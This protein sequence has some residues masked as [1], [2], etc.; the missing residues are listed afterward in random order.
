MP[1][2]KVTKV[3]HTLAKGL[4]IKINPPIAYQDEVTRGESV[5]SADDSWVEEEP[6][7]LDFFTELVPSKKAVIDYIISLFPFLQWLGHYNTQWL[8]GDLVAGKSSYPLSGCHR[9]QA[10]NSCSRYYRRL[11]RRSPGYVLRYS[12]K[13]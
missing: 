2:P 9:K 12:R 7:T 4:G 5:F 3:G 11:C 13:P 8:I 6:H 1:G 10:S